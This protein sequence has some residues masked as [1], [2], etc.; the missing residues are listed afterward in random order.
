MVDYYSPGQLKVI[1]PYLAKPPKWFILGGTA[2]AN[3]AQ[4]AA[5]LWP[6]VR[7]IGIEPN[8][9]AIAF[10]RSNGWPEGAVL[11]EA[12]LSESVGVAEIVCERGRVRNA[13]MDPVS[14]AGAGVD[15]I[16]VLTVTL[17]Y[18]DQQYGPFEDA[19]VWMDIEG[20]E[21]RALQGASRLI[22]SGRVMLWNIEMLSRVPGM[23]DG[24]PKLLKDYQAVKDWN[25]SAECRD[26]IFVRGS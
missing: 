1:L 6:G 26:R 13:S 10:Q 11:I 16:E 19:V 5:E 14:V 22:A 20:S 9:E 7:I 24:V 2:D 12:A 4:T 17:D 3:E 8:P 23:M 25:D 15:P 18:L 21:L